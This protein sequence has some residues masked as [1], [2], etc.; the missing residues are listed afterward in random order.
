M[1]LQGAGRCLA[2]SCKRPRQQACR[3]KSC[4]IDRVFVS[5]FGISQCN[6]NNYASNNII[7]IKSQCH[8]LL[9]VNE[10]KAVVF[11]NICGIASSKPVLLLFSSS[12]AAK[13]F[14]YPLL[15]AAIGFMIFA[16]VMSFTGQSFLQLVRTMKFSPALIFLEF[17][18]A[19][20]GHCRA[21]GT[22]FL[23]QI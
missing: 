20:S 2:A 22:C 6:V 12:E 23:L 5:K 18:I 7:F 4:E 21:C 3:A 15:W 8:N 11:T 10:T 19:S 13:S 9:L 1:L 14:G 16:D 17:K